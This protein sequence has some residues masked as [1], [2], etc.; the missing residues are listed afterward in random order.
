VFVIIVVA[1]VVGI[2]IVGLTGA[3]LRRLVDL[4]IRHLWLVWLAIGVQV[5]VLSLL[6]DHVAGSVGDAVHLATY[7][8]A[9]VFMIVNRRV[10]GVALMGLGG[11]ANLT[12][13]IANGGVMPASATAWRLAGRASSTGFSN[14]LPIAHPRLLVLGDV[15]A[16]PAGWPLAN[17]FSVGDT[18]LVW[19]LVWMVSHWCRQPAVVQ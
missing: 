14:S 3:D 18:L 4:P 9:V 6:A 2:I 7:G 16:L 5:G 10:R 12:A 13:I 17:V 19:G 11:A 8:V 15:F 1:S